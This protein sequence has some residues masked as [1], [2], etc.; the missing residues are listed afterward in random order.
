MIN[1]HFVAENIMSPFIWADLIPV[2][3]SEEFKREEVLKKYIKKL[4]P[5]LWFKTSKQYSL[6]ITYFHTLCWIRLSR[7][8]INRG[9]FLLCLLANTGSADIAPYSRMSKQE[10]SKNK[11]Q[12]PYKNI[13]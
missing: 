4:I 5:M 1:T 13:H 3:K 6:E 9:K 12:D 7:A 11:R 8:G 2:Y 10:N